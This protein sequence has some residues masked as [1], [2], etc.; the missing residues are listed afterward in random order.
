MARLRDALLTIL[1]DIKIFRFPMFLVYDPGSCRV[2]GHHA[3]EV[4]RCI[5]PGDVLV[6]GFEMYLDGKFIPGY[7]SHAGL[8]LGEV[9]EADRALAPEKARRRVLPG[10]QLVIH[11]IAEGVQMEDLLDFCRCDRLLVLRFPA[12]LRARAAA[13][14]D[15]AAPLD[16]AER[17]LHDRLLGGGEVAFREEA[18]PVVRRVAFSQLGRGYDFAFDFTDARRL[19][20]T[21]LVHRATRCLAPWLGVQ[22]T[23]HRVLFLSGMGI[24]P[25]D[26]AASPLELVWRS[27]SASARRVE[28]LRRRAA[29]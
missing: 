14:A 27:P 9:T 16:E 24:A 18:W 11:A 7:F 8:Y 29:R 23:L 13:P 5:E 20:C 10:E 17:A 19:S 2:K 6:R 15:P 1:G 26:F 12:R 4:L 28:V 21:E 22:P 3:R 25:D